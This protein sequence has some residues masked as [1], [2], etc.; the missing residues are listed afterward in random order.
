MI[1]TIPRPPGDPA[2]RPGLKGFYEYELKQRRGALFPPFTL[3]CGLLLHAGCGGAGVLA[4][5]LVTAQSR[6]AQALDCGRADAGQWSH[7]F[8]APAPVKRRAG[9]VP[10]PILISCCH[11]DTA[12]LLREL[13]TSPEHL[14]PGQLRLRQPQT[15]L[16]FLRP[17][18][19]LRPRKRALLENPFCRNDLFQPLREVNQTQNHLRAERG[20]IMP[21]ASC[22]MRPYPDNPH[23][24][25]GHRRGA[26]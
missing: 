7:L 2:G 10:P 1:Q 16:A 5:R 20:G 17:F 12:L 18:A 11:R 8:H 25:P 9:S 21:P 14:G 19:G 24:R 26:G 4:G 15:C 23:I 6:L 13:F 3:S 22:K